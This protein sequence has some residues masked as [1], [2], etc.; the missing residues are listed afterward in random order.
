M[1]SFVSRPPSDKA[2]GPPLQGWYW[3]TVLV[4]IPF[5]FGVV[6]RKGLGERRHQGSPSVR[7]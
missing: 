5:A 6:L 2:H 4:A 1:S 3:W 7:D